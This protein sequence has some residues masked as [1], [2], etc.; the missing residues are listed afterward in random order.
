MRAVTGGFACRCPGTK[1]TKANNVNTYVVDRTERKEKTRNMVKTYNL[2]SYDC[3]NRIRSTTSSS[4]SHT[5]G[6]ERDIMKTL[7]MVK[8]TATDWLLNWPRVGEAVLDIR[9]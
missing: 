8:S 5:H 2:V 9:H 1:H 7:T 6:K 3:A 4:D